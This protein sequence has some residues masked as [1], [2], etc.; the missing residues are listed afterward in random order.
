MGQLAGLPQEA[1]QLFFWASERVNKDSLAFRRTGANLGERRSPAK[2]LIE[3][4]H[5]MN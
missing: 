5:D 4:H 1:Y 2:S 3:K